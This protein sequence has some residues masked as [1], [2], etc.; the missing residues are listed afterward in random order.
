LI[1]RDN[2]TKQQRMKRLLFLPLLLTAMFAVAQTRSL[3]GKIVSANDQAAISKASIAVRNGKSFIA[4]DSGRFKIEVP[5][6]N[7]T[8]N[9]SSIGFAP[10]EVI[11]S[12]TDNK[13]NSITYRNK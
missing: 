4:D 1:T 7:I 8:L 3:E 5:A 6:G 12:A 13:Y 11:V 10:S 2:S 9:I